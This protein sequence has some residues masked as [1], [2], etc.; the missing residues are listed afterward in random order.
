[1]STPKVFEATNNGS[2][3]IIM[4]LGSVGSL[5]GESV[6]FELE[7]LVKRLGESGL[8]HVI[9]DFQKVSYFGSSMLG[10][11]HAVWKHVSAAEGKMAL[12]NV[13]DVEREVLEVSK[14]DTLWPVYATREQ[15]LAAI[16]PG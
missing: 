1:M 9:F 16:G 14:F 6:N 4:P 3:L 8:K 10:A 13:S 11:M 7:A 12:C 2:T 15:A 5:A